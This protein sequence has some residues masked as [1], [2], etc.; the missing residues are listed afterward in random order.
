MVLSSDGDQ[1]LSWH[2]NEFGNGFSWAAT[3]IKTAGSAAGLPVVVDMDL[4]GDP[5]IV[6]AFEESGWKVAWFENVSQARKSGI[7]MIDM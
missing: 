1:T 7:Y 5:D 2:E 6:W 4:D 3:T